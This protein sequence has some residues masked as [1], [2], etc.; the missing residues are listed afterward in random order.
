MTPTRT[1]CLTLLLAAAT[2]LSSCTS[3]DDGTLIYVPITDTVVGAETE[4]ACQ[5]AG[6]LDQPICFV[7]QG[8]DAY[9]YGVLNE[10]AP[11]VVSH[12]LVYF[13]EVERLVMVDVPGS[14]DDE[15]NLIAARMVRTA[16]LDTHIPANGWVASGGVDF[17]VAGVKRSIEQGAQVG[18]H[19]WGNHTEQGADVPR[20][21]PAHQPYIQYYQDM[22]LTNPAGFY[23]FT[24]QA[25]PAN[26][27]HI[28]SRAEIR[29]WQLTTH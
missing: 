21:H 14:E 23:F 17:F 11:T 28:M 18:V 3:F 15:F 12:L 20:N 9:M 2:L 27:I 29:Q 22:A 24:L 4:A 1:V 7:V 10:T 19:S 6:E 25:A 5:Q 8:T 26:N 13:T 16:G